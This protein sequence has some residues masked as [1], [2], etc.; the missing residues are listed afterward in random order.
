MDS[1]ATSHIESGAERRSDDSCGYE[2]KAIGNLDGR[3]PEHVPL[4]GGEEE[5]IAGAGNPDI[6]V[7]DSLNRE[8]GLRAGS[9]VSM[10]ISSVRKECDPTGF[11]MRQLLLSGIRNSAGESHSLSPVDEE[12]LPQGSAMAPDHIPASRALEMPLLLIK[13]S[14]APWVCPSWSSGR[15]GA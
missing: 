9:V 14:S 13:G 1:L 11:C 8:E 15:A 2:V 5:T 7:P 12:Y 10:C 4:R 6:R 3:I